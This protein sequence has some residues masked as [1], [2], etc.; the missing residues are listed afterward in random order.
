MD[1][2]L[3]YSTT[4][5]RDRDA[6]RRD[7]NSNVFDA[8]PTKKSS[9][10]TPQSFCRSPRARSD[11][12]APCPRP[13][14]AGNRRNFSC[15][16]H[17]IALSLRSSR[18]S[19]LRAL[20]RS[21]NSELVSFASSATLAGA[22]EASATTVA[23]SAPIATRAGREARANL[24]GTS[25][26]TPPRRRDGAGSTRVSS[27]ARTSAGILERARVSRRRATR[28]SRARCARDARAPGFGVSGSF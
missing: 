24:A 26:R 9:P 5:E 15:C 3:I 2:I 16:T 19:S 1:I 4:I 18:F 25:R 11:P 20:R 22:C 7:R 21:T 6:R 10:D 17:P 12:A 8:R 27:D 28:S 23:A 14:T 13:P